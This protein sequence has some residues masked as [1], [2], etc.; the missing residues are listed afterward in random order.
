MWFVD[1]P[2][3]TWFKDKDDE[4][5]LAIQQYFSLIGLYSEA[6]SEAFLLFSFQLKGNSTL[7]C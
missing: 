6:L 3:E 7:L 1:G 2:H 5:I 4:V